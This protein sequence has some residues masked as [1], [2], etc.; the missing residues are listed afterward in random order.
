MIARVY[1]YLC[2]CVSCRPPFELSRLLSN[3]MCEY[4]CVFVCMCVCVGGLGL[5]SDPLFLLACGGCVC[6]HVGV[7]VN[8]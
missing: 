8:V 6:V 5:I 1:V 4:V 7:G 2:V 3:C